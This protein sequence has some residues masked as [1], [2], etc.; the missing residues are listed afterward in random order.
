MNSANRLELKLMSAV[1]YNA[2]SDPPKSPRRR[3]YVLATDEQTNEQTNKQKTK[4]ANRWGL[5][6]FTDNRWIGRIIAFL[7]MIWYGI[8]VFNVPLDTL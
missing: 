2:K 8:V 3:Q 7:G 5:I 4:Q 1:N 6:V